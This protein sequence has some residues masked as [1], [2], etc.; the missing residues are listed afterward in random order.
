[1]RVDV[2]VVRRSDWWPR[3]WGF[4]LKGEEVITIVESPY[5]PHA[6]GEKETVNVGGEE[7]ELWGNQIAEVWTLRD[8]RNFLQS[9]DEEFEVAI[10]EDIAEDLDVVC[11]EGV[12]C[13]TSGYPIYM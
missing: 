3:A 12:R 11:P 6:R 7:M 10:A 13:W 4:I 8:F 2:L 9:L 1:M 5:N